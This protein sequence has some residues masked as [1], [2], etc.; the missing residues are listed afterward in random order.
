MHRGREARLDRLSRRVG[1]GDYTAAERYHVLRARAAIG[2][3][4]RW[5]LAAA[6][7][8]PQSVP[9]LRVA[10]EAAAE[11]AL[12][13]D[14]PLSGPRREQGGRTSSGDLETAFD[15]RLDRLAARYRVGPRTEPDFARA[16][17][18]ELLA[19]CIAAGEG[20]GST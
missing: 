16:S 4:V 10:E 18:A 13:G 14:P 1:E 19:W 12:L 7:I 11:L 17:L 20:V 2:A 9:A 5:Q 8:D 6:G 15:H 3:A